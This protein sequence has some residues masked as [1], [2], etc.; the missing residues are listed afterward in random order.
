MAPSPAPSL[1][2]ARDRAPVLR[3]VV[4]FILASLI[5]S[6]IISVLAFF[7]MGMTAATRTEM[8]WA[9]A[10]AA[11][12]LSLLVFAFSA[13][14]GVLGVGLLWRAGRRGILAWGASGIVLGL[15]FG[16]AFTALWM[17][18]PAPAVIIAAAV[19]GLA[20][21]LLIRAF[22]DIRSRPEGA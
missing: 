8:L 9:T 4:A 19:V 13:T 16:L 21:F 3:L 5:V 17:K 11:P 14:F 7:V 18:G 1:W 12:A 20:V 10:R 6:A 22:A 2:P 15:A